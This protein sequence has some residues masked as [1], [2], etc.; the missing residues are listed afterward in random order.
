MMP[1]STITDV[2]EFF[3]RIIEEYTCFGRLA[4]TLAAEIPSLQPAIIEQRCRLLNDERQRLTCLDD[5]L[6]DIL[7]LA[8]ENL[9]CSDHLN[10]YRK[11]FSAAV[12]AVD[13]IHAQLIALRH[14]LQD[15]TL[16]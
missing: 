14:T 6:I 9:S 3:E 2:N 7:N 5:Q 15:V 4:S 8:G 1:A 13:D 16:H 11:A 10:H 12:L